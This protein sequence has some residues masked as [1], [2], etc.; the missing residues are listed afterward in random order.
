[1]TRTRTLAVVA[2]V[3]LAIVVASV[4]L[5]GG[6]SHVLFR[7]E[8]T[9]ARV[10]AVGESG[11]CLIGDE[12]RY[13]FSWDRDGERHTAWHQ[14]CGKRFQAF[15][16]TTI[17]TDGD[18]VASTEPPWLAWSIWLLL[19]VAAA[20]AAWFA[21]RRRPRGAPPRPDTDL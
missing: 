11:H 16:E 7:T 18:Q 1:M 3:F 8:K 12:W 19:A 5:L 17:W 14:L 6:V 2:A 21:V 13:G 4:P 15:E 9:D 20:G 10:V